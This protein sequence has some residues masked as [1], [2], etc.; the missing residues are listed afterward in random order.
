MTKSKSKYVC[1]CGKACKAT[2]RYKA[3]SEECK[4][5][6]YK[7]DGGVKCAICDYYAHDLTPHITRHHKMSIVEYQRLYCGEV[8][9]EK[10]RNQ[11]AAAI[12]ADKN[13]GFQHGGKF[14]PFSTKFVGYTDESAED[15]INSLKEHCVEVK[16]QR[17]TNPL[18]LEY[19]TTKGMSEREAEAALQERQ[20]TMSLARCIDRFGEEDG[21]AKMAARNAKW[22]ATLD[23]KS[24]EEKLR[25]NRAKK[26]GG[27]AAS[28]ISLT[29]FA[30]F[31]QDG[32]FWN[33][34]ELKI[35]AEGRVFKLDFCRGNKVIEFNG[36]FW[37]ANPD[38]FPADKIMF[39][40][41]TA[42]ELWM[43]D[44]YRASII[45]QLGYEI[46]VIWESEFKADPESVISKCKHFLE[47]K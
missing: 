33:R 17:S 47:N 19:Y 11:K 44:A 31:A 45:E 18:T 30:Q 9:S 7:Q 27:G 12:A 46:L 4:S 43:R 28:K 2:L 34:N 14:S 6:I 29:M 1:I 41:F 42:E 26:Y 15:K 32:D 37:H 8:N 21:R 35:S 36:D 25:I 16:K 10:M 38:K 5:E 39:K 3:C 22:L 40:G 24:P 13:P 20:A 23:S